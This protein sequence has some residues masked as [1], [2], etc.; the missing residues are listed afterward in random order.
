MNDLKS[1]Q[2]FRDIILP[3]QVI[4]YMCRKFTSMSYPNIARLFNYD[5][6]TAIHSVKTI[7]NQRQTNKALDQ[8]L[9]DIEDILSLYYK[10]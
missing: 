9:K 10:C 2:R 3:K 7:E 4:M 6:C 1:K 8:D 5:H